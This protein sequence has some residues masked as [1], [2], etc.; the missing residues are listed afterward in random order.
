MTRSHSEAAAG[1][2]RARVRRVCRGKILRFAQND[3]RVRGG[4]VEYV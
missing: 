3:A 1:G 2:R 4:E